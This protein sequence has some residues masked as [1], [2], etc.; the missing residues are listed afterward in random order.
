MIRQDLADAGPVRGDHDDGPAVDL[1][2]L[3]RGLPGRAR[4]AGQV[5]IE[6]EEPLEADPGIGVLGGGDLD[7]LPWPRPP[8]A[9]RPA[10]SGRASRGR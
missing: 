8:G 4:H 6:P 10:R 7:A 9:G 1:P 5:L 3:G 2:E